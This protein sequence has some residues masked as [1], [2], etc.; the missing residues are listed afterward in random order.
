M[1]KLCYLFMV[2]F[3][4]FV[5]S[6]KGFTQTEQ[7]GKTVN[8]DLSKDNAEWVL[9]ES[10]EG[11]DVYYKIKECLLSTSSTPQ[12]FVLFKI[13]NTNDT[14]QYH[15]IWDIRTYYGGICSNCESN[16]Y[17]DSVNLILNPGEVIEADES[18][19]KTNSLGAF[20]GS[21]YYQE[22]EWLSSFFLNNLE[23]HFLKNV[24]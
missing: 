21:K 20:I 7:S 19:P 8:I 1:K 9:Y 16:S 13:E 18:L 6:I 11:V 2:V 24:K 14:E 3:L 10:L 22:D 12:L 5:I 17:E 4:V 15:I 23:V